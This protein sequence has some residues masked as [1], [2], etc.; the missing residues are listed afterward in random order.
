MTEDEVL[1]YLETEWRITP[2]G[3]RILESEHAAGRLSSF[4]IVE[5]ILESLA[6][7]GPRSGLFLIPLGEEGNLVA[8]LLK[9][10]ESDGFIK[11][12]G[13]DL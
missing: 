3:Q 4:F 11:R 2:R 1:E 6:M 13:G 10:L 8:R 12:V 9:A 7:E 5:C